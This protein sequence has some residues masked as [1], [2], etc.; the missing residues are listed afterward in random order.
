MIFL[1]CGQKTNTLLHGYRWM[2]RF[3]LDD[4]RQQ[5]KPFRVYFYPRLRSTNDHAAALRRA[6][7]LFCPAL[8]VA[9]HQMSG[10]GRGSNAWWS[11]KGSLTVTFGLP[12]DERILAHQVPLI[13]GLALHRAIRQLAGINDLKLKWPND[14]WHDD[15][16]LAGLLCER[17]DGAD[18]IGI[19]LNVNTD[20]DDIPTSVRH[21]VTSIRGII[22]AP[23]PLSSMLIRI[24]QELNKL[25][26][27]K[28]FGSFGA[29]L[30]EY[31][32]HH[33]LTGRRLRIIEPGGTQVSGCCE[34]LDSHGR[35]L[36]R[37]SSGLSKVVSGHV[38]LV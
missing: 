16:K 14:I 12:T 10:R 15:L 20:I 22:A 19:G 36:I 9:G 4:L 33:A 11:G 25:L 35:L 5:C 1:P 17:I 31:N 37:T 28:D 29:I 32:R 7:K 24:G 21:K 18:L 3:R 23:I 38:E 8:V 30:P 2:N 27:K 34:G 26:L 6:G 13:A